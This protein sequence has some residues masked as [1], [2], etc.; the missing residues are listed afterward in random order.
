[1]QE[2]EK[3]KKERIKHRTRD[4]QAIC[5]K[6][7][8]QTNHRYNYVLSYSV[9]FLKL[10]ISSPYSY[11]YLYHKI[12]SYHFYCF[13]FFYVWL[14]L[15]KSTWVLS[16]YVKITCKVWDSRYFYSIKKKMLESVFLKWLS[17]FILINNNGQKLFVFVYLVF[18]N[19]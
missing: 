15:L 5:G 6:T 13:F 18:R 1:M 11:F 7:A 12:H 9:T 10:E 8:S 16:L 4:E 17:K 2:I 14:L 19:K 3:H